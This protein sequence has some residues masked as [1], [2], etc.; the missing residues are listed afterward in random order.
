VPCVRT[1]TAPSQGIIL[2]APGR[3]GP[4]PHL[5]ENSFI[6]PDRPTSLRLA[7]AVAELLDRLAGRL[8]KSKT[9]I[10]ITGILAQAEQHGLIPSLADVLA[11]VMPAPTTDAETR[12]RQRL[13]QRRTRAGRKGQALPAPEPSG[14]TS[15]P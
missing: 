13:S 7:P 5:C 15:V 4:S 14:R 11:S 9:E 10:I 1:T 6:V 3:R 8:G 2:L 12:R